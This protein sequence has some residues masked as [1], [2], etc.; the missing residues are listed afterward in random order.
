VNKISLKILN[1]SVLYHMIEGDNLVQKM[2]HLEKQ[3]PTNNNLKETNY[4]LNNN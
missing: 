2:L 3:V 1:K 4:Y